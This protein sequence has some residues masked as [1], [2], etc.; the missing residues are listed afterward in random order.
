[1][2]LHNIID[3][4][5]TKKKRVKNWRYLTQLRNSWNSEAIVSKDWNSGR[6]Q[7]EGIS[8]DSMIHTITQCIYPIIYNYI[9]QQ[10]PDNQEVTLLNTSLI[11]VKR[12]N[13]IIFKYLLWHYKLLSWE[14]MC[15][16]KLKF[17]W[18][19]NYFWMYSFSFGFNYNY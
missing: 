10:R 5:W 16:I 11:I 12:N 17:W 18:N 4:V 6:F 19:I 1:M 15:S 2:C 8:S 9:V 13:Y 3:T 14:H 7:S